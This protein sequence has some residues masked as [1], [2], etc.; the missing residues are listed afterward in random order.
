MGG[1][2]VLLVKQG[3]TSNPKDLQGVRAGLHELM[4]ALWTYTHL[5]LLI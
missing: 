4:P 3:N 2:D 5:M 1:D